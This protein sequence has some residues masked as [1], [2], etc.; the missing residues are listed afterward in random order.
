MR[1]IP[2]FISSMP[3]DKN[4]IEIIKNTSC[5]VGSK[6]SLMNQNIPKIRMSIARPILSF[7]NKIYV[8]L[9]YLKFPYFYLIVFKTNYIALEIHITE[10]NLILSKLH[11]NWQLD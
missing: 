8:S 5:E 4:M 6:S 2:S 3:D 9:R 1:F 10:C 11:S 7:F